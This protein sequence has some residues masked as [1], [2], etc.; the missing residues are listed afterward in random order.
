[1]LGRKHAKRILEEALGYSKADET[2]VY[3]TGGK[4]W[5]TRFANNYIH[6]N[7][8]QKNYNITARM[9]KGKKVGVASTNVFHGTYLKDVILKAEEVLKNQVDDPYVSSLSPPCKCREIEN[10]YDENTINFTPE[11][12]AS[13]VGK[14]IKKCKKHNITAAGTHS[15]G[16]V[17]FTYMNSRNN[18]LY[19]IETSA[20]FTLTTIAD[21][22]GTG[23]NYYDGNS[24]D[25]IN[26]ESLTDTAVKKALLNK[27]PIK[28]TPG[29]Y[30]VILEEAAVAN[31]IRFLGYLGFGALSYQEGRSFM[32]GKI[33]TKIMGDNITI[34]D[35]VYRKEVSGF[36]FD[37]EG[38]P[39]KQVTLIENGI[40]KA[41]VYDMKRAAKD[42]TESTGHALPPPS[43]GGPQPLNLV[44]LPGKTG[45]EEIIKNTKK[46]ILVSRLWYDNVVDPK[47]TIVT[48]LT[49]DGT[50]LIEN[51]E[52]SGAVQNM[53]Y[54]NS[55]LEALSC[56][57]HISHKI[58]NIG[59]YGIMTACPAI[60]IENFNFSGISA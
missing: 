59:S 43:T 14:V 21:N 17:L 37:F 46:A 8:V 25:E 26:V 32:A 13:E 45:K 49:R 20:S 40:A 18:F 1:M 5:L 9:I 39:R 29:S 10:A 52:I 42:N 35:D 47:K 31:L 48:G 58:K 2:E 51:G 54:N 12:S 23:W 36:P 57:S 24:I 7:V 22:G 56:V 34:M 33:G 15:F 3:I 6:Q 60:K 4:N 50:F 44:L 11:K 27:D 55:I 53:R 38:I 19:H 16:D 28:L 41:V 30:P